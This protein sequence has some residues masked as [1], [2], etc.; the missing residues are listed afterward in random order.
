MSRK[1]YDCCMFLNEN[2]LYEIRINQHWDFVDYFIVLE[3]G[4]THTGVPKP[5]KF[6]QK[7]FEKYSSKLKY[8]QIDNLDEEM[9]KFPR[10]VDNNLINSKFGPTF[11]KPD[12]L[13]DQFQADYMAKI[14]FDLGATNE[15]ITYFSCL[16]E[17]LK[18]EAFEECV[19]IIDQ[20]QVTNLNGVNFSPIFG[21]DMYLYA[22]KINLLHVRHHVVG[23][24]TEIGNFK[25]MSPA[26]IRHLGL[27]THPPIQDGGWHF[28]FLDPTDGELVLEKQRSWAHSKDFYQGKKTKFDHTTKEEAVARFFED[29]HPTLVEIKEGTHPPYLLENLDKYQ[30]LIYKGDLP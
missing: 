12:W 24:L 20:K 9:L 7:R 19:K 1:V 10:L 30:N 21:F 18:K 13:R 11:H 15:D 29:Y 26:R 16:D 8:F 25:K 6:D 3:A 23:M 17:L 2:D 28:T 27:M 22:Y 5:F 14:L 4:Q